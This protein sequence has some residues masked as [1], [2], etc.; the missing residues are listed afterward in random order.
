MGKLSIRQAT[1]TDKPAVMKIAETVWEGNDYLPEV[2]DR[3]VSEPSNE[4]FLMTGEIE[5]QVV[6]VQHIDFQP[7]Q[8]AWLEGIRVDPAFRNQGIGGRMLGRA[9]KI[10]K[11]HRA[12]K[13]RLSTAEL[14]PMSAAIATSQGLTQIAKFHIYTAM[15]GEG[16]R[17]DTNSRQAG[18]EVSTSPCSIDEVRVSDDEL[19]QL[20]MESGQN[21]TLIVT[22]WTAYDL[23]GQMSTDDFPISFACRENGKLVGLA[24]ANPSRN[25]E[26]L[27]I[28]TVTGSRPAIA[29]LG[30]HLVSHAKAWG[31]EAIQAMLPG[32]PERGA[33][34]VH[35]GFKRNE[36]LVGLLFECSL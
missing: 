11:E 7:K 28:A 30:H 18:L 36:Q 15:T 35:A 14:N 3:W 23:P 12:V 27:S 22:Q 17:N 20:R 1:A 31:Y 2:W 25:D 29:T 9:L 8:V 33:G 5:G 26:K 16:E 13:A 21:E 34:L 19:E 32:G 4:G 6:A 10:A 24:L